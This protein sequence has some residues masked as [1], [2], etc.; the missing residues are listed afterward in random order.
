MLGEILP[1]ESGRSYEVFKEEE[2]PEEPE[3]GKPAK[4][5]KNYLY[6]REVQ[7]DEKMHFF[8]FPKLGGFACY[9]LKVK[10]CLFGE[11][12][13]KGK[14]DFKTFTA[15]KGQVEGEF[16]ER[17]NEATNQFEEAKRKY[18]EHE[19]NEE[20]P[21]SVSEHAGYQEE[22]E[23]AEQALKEVESSPPVI[24]PF[25]YETRV[26]EFVVCLDTMGRDS[27]MCEQ[28]LDWVEEKVA[29]FKGQW[30]DKEYEMLLDDIKLYIEEEGGLEGQFNYFKDQEQAII[31]ANESQIKEQCNNR[32]KESEYELSVLKVGKLLKVLQEEAFVK[33]MQSYLSY[34][35]P[36]YS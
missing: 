29:Y 27:S 25:V 36:K 34:N 24:E 1:N 16:K 33:S 22:F 9:P 23:K 26:K 5:K 11:S 28:L 13:D 30:E 20:D 31:G 15:N 19:I 14:E 32:E 3:E 4:V 17:L 12:F 10:S 8:K 21:T 2:P 6:V 7:R 35:I 18:E